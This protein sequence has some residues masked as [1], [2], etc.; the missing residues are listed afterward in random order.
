MMDEPKSNPA[1]LVS[2]RYLRD[3]TAPDFKAGKKGDVKQIEAHWAEQ[4]VAEGYCERVANDPP[5]AEAAEAAHDE[6]PSQ[7]IDHA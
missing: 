7:E 5:K 6:S 2:V 4:L 1:P 3:V